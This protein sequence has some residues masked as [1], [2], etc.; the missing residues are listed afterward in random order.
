[1]GRS[2]ELMEIRKKIQLIDNKWM[3]TRFKEEVDLESRPLI[4]IDE[5][6]KLTAHG[7]IDEDWE[8]RNEKDPNGQWQVLENAGMITLRPA[9]G[10]DE[11]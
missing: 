3:S 4:T 6:R 7:H 1:M 11:E 5:W 10:V 9:P 8:Q 2:E